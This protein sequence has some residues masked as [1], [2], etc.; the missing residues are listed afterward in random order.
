M[1]GR[2]KRTTTKQRGR[3]AMEDRV[4]ALEEEL[5]Q[6]REHIRTEN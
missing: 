4:K 6:M 5:G 3:I 2:P 1:D